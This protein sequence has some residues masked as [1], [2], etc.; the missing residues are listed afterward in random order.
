MKKIIISLSCMFFFVIGG[1][2][3]AS[4]ELSSGIQYSSEAVNDAVSSEIPT[5][6][7]ITAENGTQQINY[8]NQGNL[9]KCEAYSQ[10]GE[11]NEVRFYQD[12][13]LVE[14][15]VLENGILTQINIYHQGQLVEVDRL[16]NSTTRIVEKYQ[17][18]QLVS[19][20]TYI[21]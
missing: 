3:E 14:S 16:S 17:D 6:E 13:K 2:F 1:Q 19:S 8:Y 15:R 18:E 9:V 4:D 5:T 20:E 10:D 12:G 7:V 11:M 21:D